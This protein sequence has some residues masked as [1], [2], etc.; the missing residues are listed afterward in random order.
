MKKEDIPQHNGALNKL[1]REV[2]Y[3][4][5]HT[6][7]YTTSLSSGWDVKTNALDVAWQDIAQRIEMARSKVVS[8]EASPLLFFMEL[9]LMDTAIVSAYTGFWQWQVKRHLKPAAFAKLSQKKLEKYAN[10]FNVTVEQL[11]TMDAHEG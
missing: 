8:H 1:T 5:D 2:V 11:K 4:V 7:V 10:A 9:R 6:G 3:A